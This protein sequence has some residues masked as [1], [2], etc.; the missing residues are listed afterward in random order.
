MRYGHE[1][2]DTVMDALRGGIFSGNKGV[3]VPLYNLGCC[4][5]LRPPTNKKGIITGKGAERRV[6][7]FSC[8]SEQNKTRKGVLLPYYPSVLSVQTY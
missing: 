7:E 5:M 8:L 2:A 4:V 6:K 3:F 1:K